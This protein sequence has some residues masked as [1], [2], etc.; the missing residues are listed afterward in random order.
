MIQCD[1]EKYLFS[2]A[3]LEQT[4]FENLKV[5]ICPKNVGFFQLCKS[6][7]LCYISSS[8]FLEM[9]YEECI[10]RNRFDIGITFK[11]VQQSRHENSYSAIFSNFHYLK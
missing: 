5:N 9:F 1:S 10:C 3:K 8:H 6:P 7:F 4:N 11:F 2:P